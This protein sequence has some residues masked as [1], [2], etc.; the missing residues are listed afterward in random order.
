M[1]E[2]SIER[3][4]ISFAHVGWSELSSQKVLD[5]NGESELGSYQVLEASDTHS[6]G[7]SE[8]GSQKVL[9]ASTHSSGELGVNLN[10]WLK[11]LNMFENRGLQSHPRTL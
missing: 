7:E 10:R 2:V 3:D 11:Y 9:D 6:S 8:L 5:P 1:F 4:F